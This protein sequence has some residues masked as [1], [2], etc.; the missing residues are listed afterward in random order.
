MPGPGPK[1]R[2]PPTWSA[3]RSLF[4]TAGR[5]PHIPVLTLVEG[6]ADAASV[7]ETGLSA[8]ATYGSGVHAPQ[9]DLIVA[10]RPRLIL[11]GFDDDEA[12]ERATVQA[13]EAL[14]PHAEIGFI[15]WGGVAKD[16]A[17]LEPEA[18]FDA[19]LEAVRA[20][21]YGEQI[22]ELA[23]HARQLASEIEKRYVEECT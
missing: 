11:L 9:V 5:W 12:G 18:R 10:Q 23:S 15:S 3:S 16:P 14:S 21:S 4:G 13:Y 17:D 22:D 6:A 1:Y 20:S 8:E 2:Y 7:I 19:V